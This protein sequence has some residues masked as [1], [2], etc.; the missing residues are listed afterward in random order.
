MKNNGP[1]TTQERSF[2][3]TQRLITTTDT[4]GTITYCNDA[5]VSISGFERDQ[6]LG[7]PHNIVRHPDMP[8]AVFGHMWSHLKTGK[9]WMGIIKNRCQ[10]GDFYWVNAYV[11]PIIENGR[12]TGYESV[13]VKPDA[14]HVRRATALYARMRASAWKGA[15]SK[16]WRLVKSLVVPLLASLLVLAVFFVISPSAAAACAVIAFFASQLYHNRLSEHLMLRLQNTVD[17]AF[18]SELIAR[19]YTD[20]TGKPAQ[21]QMALISERARI[22]TVLSRLAD[23][24]D[25]SSELARRSGQLT[26][27]AETSLLAQRGEADKTAAAMH[28]MAASIAEVS[29]HVHRTADEANRAHTLARDGS[30]EAGKTR[31]VIEGLA[32][33]VSG[34]SD[35]VGAL[36]RNTQAIE[37]AADM[38][39]AIADQTNLLAL[40]AAIEAARAGEQGRGFAV[41]ADEVRALASKTQESTKAIQD[42]IKTL[43]EGAQNAV[44]IAQAGTQEATAGV[45]QVIATQAALQGISSA[46]G[47]IHDMGQQMA[48]ASEEQAHVAEDISRQITR[49]AEASDHNSELAKESAQVGNDLKRTSHAMHALVERFSN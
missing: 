45:Q 47:L 13:R 22:R 12:V 11:T 42:I 18:D 35:S 27:S 14:E 20:L 41:V 29:A 26:S 21:I 43:L 19:T 10:N 8:E 40:N 32:Q 31:E 33:T 28:D 44:T 16:R 34:I 6:L 15:E 39:R 49:I 7:A 17:G 46:V 5:F 1:V 25:H 23:Y 24:A 38:I 3:A 2:P 30:A 4:N 48:T 37:Q 36:A 9:A